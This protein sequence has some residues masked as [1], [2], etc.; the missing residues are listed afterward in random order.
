[1]Q[2]RLITYMDI[3]TSVIK[4]ILKRT[5]M[6]WIYNMEPNK[7]AFL[8]LV[9]KIRTKRATESQSCDSNVNWNWP[10]PSG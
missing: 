4:E 1:M 8:T 10:S 9:R 5:E 3:I 2:V 6:F 7:V